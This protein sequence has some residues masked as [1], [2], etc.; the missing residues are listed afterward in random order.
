MVRRDTSVRRETDVEQVP[1][2]LRTLTREVLGVALEALLV[3]LDSVA[4]AM[5][6]SAV[7]LDTLPAAE[8]NHRQ[9][10]HTLLVWLRKLGG[11][12]GALTTHIS[13][14][15]PQVAHVSHLPCPV[16]NC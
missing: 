10:A 4:S 13:H 16:L 6:G 8:R 3:A 15:S 5:N 14:V 1:T 12:Y 2:A 9:V 7:D 11:T